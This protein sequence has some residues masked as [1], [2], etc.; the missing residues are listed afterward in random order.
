VLFRSRVASAD[1]H[2][3]SGAYG[4]AVDVSANAGEDAGEPIEPIERSAEREEVGGGLSHIIHAVGLGLAV[5]VV[6]VLVLRRS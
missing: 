5:L 1:A 4:F 2:P 6:V 3:V